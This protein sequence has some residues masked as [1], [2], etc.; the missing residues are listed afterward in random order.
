MPWGGVKFDKTGQ[1][2]LAEGLLGQIQNDEY[3]IIWPPHFAE[4]RAIWPAPSWDER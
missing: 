1:N 4:T 3:K 2:I